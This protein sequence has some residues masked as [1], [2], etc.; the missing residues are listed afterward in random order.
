MRGSGMADGGV[1]KAFVRGEKGTFYYLARNFALYRW[2]Q[3]R[4]WLSSKLMEA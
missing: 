4:I 1:V 3:Q 2:I